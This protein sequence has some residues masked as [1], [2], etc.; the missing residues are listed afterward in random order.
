MGVALRG[1]G[2]PKGYLDKCHE[3]RDSCILLFPQTEY[4]ANYSRKNRDKETVFTAFLY[5]HDMLAVCQS[6]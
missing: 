4:R 2:M 6:E 1:I 3:Q 5:F